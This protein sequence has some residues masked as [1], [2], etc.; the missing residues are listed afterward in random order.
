MNINKS[1]SNLVKM[2]VLSL[3]AAVS[4]V[5]FFVSFPIPLM[6]PYLKID[7]SDVPALIAALIFSPLAGII[8]L[9]MK[10][11]L[12]YLVTGLTD[13][14][15]I[16]AN[17]I[18]GMIIISPVAYLYH[19]FKSIKSIIYGLAIGVVAMA[20]VM[21]ILNY[22]FIL[23]V[24]VGLGFLPEMTDK[25]KFITVISGILPFNLIKGSIV[26]ILFVLLFKKLNVWI[27]QKQSKFVS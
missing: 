5:L 6:P 7:F 10:A 18:A 9:F 21:T 3:M 8:V 23:P 25:A 13:P 15:G 12:Y 16:A 26:G 19:R 4:L 20:I 1:S 24:Y 11:V 27:G 14:V 17:F 22:Y 2:I